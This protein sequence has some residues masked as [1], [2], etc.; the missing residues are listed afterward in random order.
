MTEPKP[1]LLEGGVVLK[2]TDSEPISQES[3]SRVSWIGQSPKLRYSERVAV[4][5]CTDACGLGSGEEGSGLKIGFDGIERRQ[6]RLIDITAGAWFEERGDH[7]YKRFAGDMRHLMVGMIQLLVQTSNHSARKG[8]ACAL[9]NLKLAKG[10]HSQ[11]R[12][13]WIDTEWWIG[14]RDLD[15]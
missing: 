14:G 10:L 3:L 4:G 8:D 1:E 13:I 15:G 2:V 7:Q 11:K 9:N 6:K 5:D 12:D